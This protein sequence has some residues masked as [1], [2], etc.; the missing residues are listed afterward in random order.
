MIDYNAAGSRYQ[1]LKW[2]ISFTSLEK[3]AMQLYN[4]NTRSY[5]EVCKMARKVF[6][7]ILVEFNAEG[8][9]RPL[10]ITWDDGREFDIDRVLD[11]R[12]A[13]S[14]Q[15]GGAGMRY[16][17]VIRGK[18]VYLYYDAPRWFMEGKG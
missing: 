18:S 11:A 7:K 15:A 5:R 16:T 1:C 9:M 14:L 8:M 6:V 3:D 10:K 12:Q 17:C 13:A 4:T 2:Y